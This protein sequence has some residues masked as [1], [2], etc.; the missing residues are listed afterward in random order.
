MERLTEQS[1]IEPVQFT[2]WAAP[3]VP[4]MKPDGSVRICGVMVNQASKLDNYPLPRIEDQFAKLQG[5]K[6]FTTFDSTQAYT[7]SWS[8]MRCHANLL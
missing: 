3:I 8:W 7:N 4:V 1:V 5:G 2:D 6:T